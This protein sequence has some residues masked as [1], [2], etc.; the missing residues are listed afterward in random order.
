[1][2]RPRAIAII[3]GPL[4][5]SES[6]LKRYASWYRQR[7][8]VAVTGV[9]P[10]WH[11]VRNASLQPTAMEVWQETLQVL[12]DT[13]SDV[14]VVVHMFSNGGAFVW[15]QMDRLLATRDAGEYDASTTA[16]LSVDDKTLLKTRLSFGYLMFD[17]CPC[18]IRTLW[19]TSTPWS[20]SFP[21]RGWSPMRRFLYTTVAATS[22]T[23]WLVFSLS[24]S[25]PQHFWNQM[26]QSSP[27]PH[28]VYVY[29]TEDLASD[30]A[31]VDRLVADRQA[32]A[33][34]RG[35]STTVYRYDD[36]NH[37]RIDH[38]H[39]EEYQRMIDEALEAA[40]ARAAAASDGVDKTG[41]E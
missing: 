20:A 11:F 37:C 24:W 28:H 32:K 15:E 38:D 2:A 40:L 6:M 21:H 5:A 17:S 8:C 23:A 12:R 14:P 16:V 26:T 27:C 13:P 31:A 7:S 30:A 41:D 1:M 39:P 29:T 4:G 22:L 35:T 10:P 3:L 9:S 34:D 18:Y 36:S 33:S 25:R 19:D